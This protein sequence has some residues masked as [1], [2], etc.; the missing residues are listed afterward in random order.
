M[1]ADLRRVI[2]ASASPR[3][4][5]L[6]AAAGFDF[7]VDP[8]DIDETPQPGEAP[9]RYV[10]RLAET[11]AR[12]VAGRRRDGVVLGADTTV[13]VDGAILG[14]PVDGPDAAAM[15]ARLQGRGHQVLTGVA[16]VAGD[17]SAVAVASTDVWFAPMTRADIVE[18]VASD[19]PKD[20]AG[21]YAIQ[22][23]ASRYVQRIDGSY[24]N[25]VGLPVALVHELLATCPAWRT[26][27]SPRPPDPVDR[28][29]GQGYS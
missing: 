24:S 29:A 5:E 25:V 11:K 27:A 6:L 18:Y 12:I 13:V 14:K 15:L 1:A 4:A 26:D 9:E 16:L 3:R 28:V 19:E 10:A 22:G 2:L 23:R 20:K 7:V 17:W 21:A 8:T